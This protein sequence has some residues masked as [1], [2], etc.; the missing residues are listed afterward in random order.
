[1]INVLWENRRLA[2]P[3]ELQSL[4]IAQN[5]PGFE[6]TNTA[7]FL[8]SGSIII[9]KKIELG[10]GYEN[11][12]QVV[13]TETTPVHKGNVY[14]N[15]DQGLIPRVHGSASYNRDANLENLFQDP[16]DENTIVGANVVFELSSMIGLS[17]NYNR[18]FQ[19]ND[20]TGNF[21][22]I[23]SFGITTVFTFF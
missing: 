8:I 20:Q 13:G 23:D 3:S 1:M 11:Y 10:L 19:Y 15:I 17:V 21:D 7:G 4:I 6:N 9:I 18:T 22:P 14:L 5:A 16:F 12:K 2:Y